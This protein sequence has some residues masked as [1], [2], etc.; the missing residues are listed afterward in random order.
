MT[1][2]ATAP[3]ETSVEPWERVNLARLPQLREDFDLRKFQQYAVYLAIHQRIFCIALATG[4]G[5]TLCAFACYFYYV[6]VRK[7]RGIPVKLLI[8]TNKSAVLQFR[9]ELD[10]FFVH[11]HKALAVHRQMG[12]LGAKDYAGARR[13]AYSLFAD[14]DPDLGLDVL[15][16]NYATFRK[17][18]KGIN[19]A[20]A[21]ARK[22]G[23]EIFLV[24]DE[25]TVFK[26]IKT[27]THTA[28]AT[29]ARQSARVLGLTATLT[30]GKLEEIYGIYKGMGHQLAGSKEEFEDKYCIVFKHP[31]QRFIR[32]VTGYKNTNEF[33]KLLANIAIVLRKV[34]VAKELPAFLPPRKI[35]VEHDEDQFRLI[36]DIYAGVIKPSVETLTE[37]SLLPIEDRNPFAVVPEAQ[38]EVV[39][40]SGNKSVKRLSEQGHVRRAL[41][42]KRI[43]TKESPDSK[44]VSPKTEELLRLLTDEYTTEKIVVYT[45]SKKY[46]KILLNAVRYNESLPKGYQMPL[47]I[48]GDVSGEDRE[49]NK[50]RFQ[51]DPSYNIIFIN[52]AGL[53]SINLQSASVLMLMQMPTSGGNLVQL[54]GRLSRIGSA[55]TNLQILYFMVKDSQDEDEYLIIH[56]QM[57][58]VAQIMGEAEQGLI[59]WDTLKDAS[60][61]TLL[62]DL[63]GDISDEDFQRLSMSQLLLHSRKRRQSFYTRAAQRLDLE[64]FEPDSEDA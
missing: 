2:P 50:E 33:A 7:R 21:A 57:Q 25:A 27:K 1:D 56:Q 24:L 16:M 31:R 62:T 44:Y 35:F 12:K 6:M 58:L 59:D 14:P 61:A 42:D 15:V 45:Q 40:E 39:E 51:T 55:H 13:N 3:A 64:C 18:F 26:N 17:D 11:D 10:K 49:R 32:K 63:Q 38:A 48:S 5:K 9:N 28:V 43:V 36:S 20:V 4:L 54:A 47:E 8:C 46:L 23:Q 37:D 19:A 30:K 41:L 29:I 34:D 53:E 60:T 22:S 52:D